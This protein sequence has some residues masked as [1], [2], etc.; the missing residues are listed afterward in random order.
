MCRTASD[1]LHDRERQA[2]GDGGGDRIRPFADAL[3]F[4][5]DRIEAENIAVPVGPAGGHFH[6]APSLGEGDAWVRAGAVFEV[7]VDQDFDFLERGGVILSGLLDADP[8][9]RAVIRAGAVERDLEFE[10]IGDD[11]EYALLVLGLERYEI[12]PRQAL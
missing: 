2:E 7:R 8:V 4:S 11:V 1:R 9:V 6:R 5:A 3:D 10:I 12:G